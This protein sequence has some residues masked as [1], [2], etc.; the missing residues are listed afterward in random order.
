[1]AVRCAS[2]VPRYDPGHGSHVIVKFDKQFC[3]MEVPNYFC[4]A[5][6][7]A[8]HYFWVHNTIDTYPLQS[9]TISNLFSLGCFRL[10][11]LCFSFGC[12][13]EGCKDA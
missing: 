12:E 5:T 7:E 3:R 13:M 4:H 10:I 2:L 8:I 1:M 9:T 11:N 6:S